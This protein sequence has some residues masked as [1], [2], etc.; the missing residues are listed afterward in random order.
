MGIFL[1]DDDSISLLCVEDEEVSRLLLQKA[2][3]RKFPSIKIYSAA[4]GLSGLELFDKISPKIVLT[5]INMP[6]MNGILMASEIKKLNPKTEILILSAQEK[7]CYELD[8]SRIGIS[9]YLHKPIVFEEVFHA[10][11][12]SVVSITSG[13]NGFY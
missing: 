8:F 4:N 11:Q 13:R 5:D 3:S 7:E 9:Y 2:I 6:S 10:I 1:E 12:N